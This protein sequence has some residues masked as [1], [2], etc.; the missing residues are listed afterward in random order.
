MKSRHQ[1]VCISL[2][3]SRSTVWHTEH[4]FC[5]M[6]LLIQGT[7]GLFYSSRKDN[8]NLCT[9]TLCCNM[10]VWLDSISSPPFYWFLKWKKPH[11]LARKIGQLNNPICFSF[12][13]CSYLIVHE[14]LKVSHL[15]TRNETHD[16]QSGVLGSSQ[17]VKTVPIQHCW[18]MCT[19]TAVPT[20]TCPS[21][22]MFS[23]SSI[24]IVLMV[25]NKRLSHPYT[26]RWCWKFRLQP[27]FACFS[28]SAVFSSLLHD[29]CST[30]PP[31][32]V[33]GNRLMWD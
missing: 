30:S 11:T 4:G 33:W 28:H 27:A 24:S 15:Y 17:S 16:N 22:F 7:E 20:T 19:S 9:N 5:V 12:W 32:L 21:T 31:L 13:K 3:G 18:W 2:N 25:S 26:A 6:V 14:G 8:D 23:V 29:F 1:E 10:H